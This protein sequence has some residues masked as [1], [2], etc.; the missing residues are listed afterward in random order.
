MVVVPDADDPGRA[1]G[2]AVARTCAA[3]GLAVKVADLP[4]GSKDASAYLDAGHGDALPA[5]L[6]R[7]S[8]ANLDSTP[9]D[10]PPPLVRL[11]AHAGRVTLLHAREKVGKSTLVGAAVAAVTR[12]R[13]FLAAPTRAGDVL[14]VGEEAASDVKARLAQWDA[15]LERV[16]LHPASAP[17]PGA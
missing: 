12:G 3:A 2:E 10:G 1:H 17:R 4:D 9:A 13:P 8:D 5:G 16:Y 14:W 6:V 11:I 15:D 7:L